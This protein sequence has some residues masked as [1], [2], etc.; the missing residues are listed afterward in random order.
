MS[1]P[2]AVATGLVVRHSNLIVNLNSPAEVARMYLSRLR[3]S[4]L[5]E[6]HTAGEQPA[7]KKRADYNANRIR[8]E[9]SSVKEKPHVGQPVGEHYHNPAAHC[10]ATL[11]NDGSLALMLVIT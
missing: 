4:R 3:H 1:E 7:E 11:R 6:R 5:R 8:N 2:E 9:A 10:H